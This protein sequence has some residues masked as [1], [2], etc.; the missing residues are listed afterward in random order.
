MIPFRFF[1][2]GSVTVKSA[3][4]DLTDVWSD[5]KEYVELLRNGPFPSTAILATHLN[6]ATPYFT[7]YKTD[8]N[9]MVTV[10]RRNSYNICLIIGGKAVISG[11]RITGSFGDKWL[12]KA[13][14]HYDHLDD[15]LY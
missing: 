11:H 4:S 6:S 10:D 5:V 2:R 15:D 9:V 13:I 14:A 1:A 12:Q 3:F 7:K 8:N